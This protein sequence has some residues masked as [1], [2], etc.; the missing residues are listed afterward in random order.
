MEL[1]RIKSFHPDQMGPLFLGGNLPRE[2]S[3]P[4][5]RAGRRNG[6]ATRKDDA[7]G[8]RWDPEEDQ[9]SWCPLT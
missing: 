5:R 1:T 4:R 9:H 6:K 2:T 3:A 8:F 7:D